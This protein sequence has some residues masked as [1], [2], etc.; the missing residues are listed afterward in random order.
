MKPFE[1]PQQTSHVRDG[2]GLHPTNPYDVNQRSTYPFDPMDGE[3]ILTSHPV[4]DIILGLFYFGYAHISATETRHLNLL[5]SK[6]WVQAFK[7]HSDHEYWTW[8]LTAA[9]IARIE[10]SLARVR[11]PHE[12][13]ASAAPS[14]I[15][16]SSMEF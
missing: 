2:A 10:E 4:Q 3:W 11:T 6:G 8:Q 7:P 14:P 12:K 15:D 1:F 16:I 5:V 9:A 13:P